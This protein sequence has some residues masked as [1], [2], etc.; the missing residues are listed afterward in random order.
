MAYTM[1]YKST[2]DFFLRHLLSLYREV[3][4]EHSRWLEH[5]YYIPAIRHGAANFVEFPQ[6]VGTR[7]TSG[8]TYQ[9]HDFT[10]ATQQTATML[11]SGVAS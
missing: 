1:F 6:I 11:K 3:D 2:K 10:A 4:E 8:G 7:G 9:G 5:V